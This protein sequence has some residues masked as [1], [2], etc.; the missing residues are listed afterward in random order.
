MVQYFGATEPQRRLAPHVH[1]AIR[2]AI[3]R[4]VI[5]AVARATYVQLWWPSFETP[6]YVD[7]APSCGR[8]PVH[9]A[10]LLLVTQLRGCAGGAR[11]EIAGM[12]PQTRQPA[13]C[14]T[15]PGVKGGRRPSRGDVPLMPGV[16]VH[17]VVGRFV[18]R[19]QRAWCP[20]TARSAARSGPSRR[21]RA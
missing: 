10:R 4:E 9:P 1:L 12:V 3:S 2:G 14:S 8:A 20:G 16:G 7:Q 19:S 11:N 13:R 21:R 6:V 17:I 15:V 5:R 18:A